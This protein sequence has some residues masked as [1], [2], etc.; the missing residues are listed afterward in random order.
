MRGDFVHAGVPSPIPRGHMEFFPLFSAGW[1]RRNPYWTRPS[2]GDETFPWQQPSI[3]FAYPDVG[4]PDEQGLMA[5][6]YP[7]S[8]TEALMLPVKGETHPIPKKQ[9]LL[10]KK[11]CLRN[12]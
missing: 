5:V 9:R 3:P 10:M 8:V 1:T 6:S 11:T 4:T 2:A 7:V 12:Y